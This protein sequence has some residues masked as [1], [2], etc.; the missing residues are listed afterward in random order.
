MVKTWK[1]P[2]NRIN[3]KTA[4]ESVQVLKLRFWPMYFRC[5]YL[6]D[7]THVEI[8]KYKF[9]STEMVCGRLSLLIMFFKQACTEFS[10]MLVGFGFKGG[11][12]APCLVLHCICEPVAFKKLTST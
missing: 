5:L 2:I 9:L 7:H 11:L 4:S 12:K 6:R 8:G 1:L 3:E 10:L